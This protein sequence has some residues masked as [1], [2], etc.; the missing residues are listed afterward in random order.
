MLDAEAEYP[1]E[2]LFQYY[3][4]YCNKNGLKAM[5]QANF[6]KDVESA[7]PTITRKTDRLG[8]RRVWRGLRFQGEI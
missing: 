7:S 4:D 5:S 3:R 1:R 8:K 6:N 2:E